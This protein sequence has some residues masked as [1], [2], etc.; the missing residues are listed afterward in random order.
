M[1]DMRKFPHAFAPVMFAGI[2]CDRCD[3]CALYKKNP[4]HLQS[5]TLPG[6]ESAPAERETAKG[7]A[8]TAELSAE[9]LRPL[10][11]VSKKAGRMEREAPLFFGTGEN[12]LLF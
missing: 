7:L 3:L 11:N 2:E 9:L 1:P 5:E 12:P 6:M 10:G 8:Q 4:V